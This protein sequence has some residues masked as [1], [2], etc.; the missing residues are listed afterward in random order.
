MSPVLGLSNVSLLALAPEIRLNIYHHFFTEINIEIEPFLKT[1]HDRTGREIE[2]VVRMRK[3]S[4]W[5]PR[6]VIRNQI[7]FLRVSRQ[8]YLEATPIFRH[9]INKLKIINN[10]YSHYE[11]WRCGGRSDLAPEIVPAQYI[12]SLELPLIS[13][14]RIDV[15]TFPNLRIIEFVEQRGRLRGPRLPDNAA[16]SD[17]VDT[18][19]TAELRLEAA[20]MEYS[21]I[22]GTSKL[23]PKRVFGRLKELKVINFT[24]FMTVKARNGIDAGR[25][26]G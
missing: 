20:A 10:P 12:K 3:P 22:L 23:L 21:Q 4:F 26:V 7:N 13:Q 11:A 18:S 19:L 16:V 6:S 17:T 9:L 2:C 24:V 8:I 1:E 25:I 5:N 14:R 15:L